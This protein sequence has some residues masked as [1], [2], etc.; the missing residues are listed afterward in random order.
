VTSEDVV[1]GYSLGE[2]Y[3]AANLE[4]ARLNSA[5]RRTGAA[6]VMVN[7]MLPGLR[8]PLVARL[9]ASA[10]GRVILT[11]GSNDLLVGAE[12]LSAFDGQRRDRDASVLKRSLFEKRRRSRSGGRSCLLVAPIAVERLLLLHGAVVGSCVVGFVDG[13]VV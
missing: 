11:V 5:G 7:L 2:E 8:P 12:A 6:V 3:A 1:R 13:S 9:L 10:M 4:S